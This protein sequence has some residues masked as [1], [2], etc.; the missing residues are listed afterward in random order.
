MV[1]KR[2]SVGAIPKEVMTNEASVLVD[3]DANNKAL[4]A[5]AALQE[6]GS[7]VIGQVYVNAT[8]TVWDEDGGRVADE[9][10]RLVEKAIQSRDFT[11]MTETVNAIEAGLAACRGMSTP[12]CV[13]RRSRSETAAV[14]FL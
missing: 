9:K 5:D 6:L 13:S 8:V 11:C 4:D 12:T 7:D 3:T 1:A 10:L 2:K 14:R